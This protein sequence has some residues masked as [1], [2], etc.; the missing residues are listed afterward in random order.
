MARPLR[1]EYPGAVYHVSSRGHERSSIFR[2]DEDRK[3]FLKIFRTVAADQG[4]LVHAYCLMGNHYHLL[5]ET[6]AANLSLGMRSLNS[7]YGQKF[8]R[9]HGRSGHVLEGRYKAILVQKE[10]HLLELHR[11]VVLNPVRARLVRRPGEWPWS[12]YRA[13]SGR[14][15]VPPWLEVDWTLSQFG[16]RRGAARE[17]YRRFVLAGKGLPSPLEDVKGQIYLGE[18]RFV[19]AVAKQ[20]PR[21][22]ADDQIPL[23][24]RRPW[25]VSLE[26]VR[27][28]VAR[29]FGV[30]VEALSRMRG[31]EEKMAAIYLARKLTGLSGRG[32]SSAFGVKEARVSNVIREIEEG[33]RKRLRARVER[34]RATLLNV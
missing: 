21:P 32:V 6:R 22:S 25:Q 10:S 12:N 24:Q 7:R 29:E 13:T 3:S 4:W 30:S 19:K 16:L 11:Y 8:N 26:S 14:S 34:L 1:I 27:K 28:S 9:R 2:D 17:A 5:L 31:G 23:R 18:E 15:A 33:G 20:L